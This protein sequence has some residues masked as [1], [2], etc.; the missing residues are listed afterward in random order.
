MT[1]EYGTAV[2]PTDAD[3]EQSG[4]SQVVA[5]AGD[6]ASNVVET[7]AGGIRD[8]G[9]EVKTQAQA[10]A[11]QAKQ[12][13]DDLLGQVRKEVLQQAQQRN[14]QAASQLH[15]WSD[16][17]VALAQ[18]TPEDA[19]PLVGYLDEV[20]HQVRRLA[21]R[22][23]QRGPQGVVEDVANFARRCPGVF[24]AGAVGLGFVIGRAVRAA[25]S[26]QRDDG[27]PDQWTAPSHSPQRGG[28]GSDA[29]LPSS[30]GPVGVA[31]GIGQ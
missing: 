2:P 24:L 25:S 19:G 15:T 23:D 18:G 12:Q 5:R 21:T 20:E 10:V 14:E 16:Q 6:E 9:D 26:A 22:L 13:L 4:P 28:F 30:Y 1:V 7:A 3:G 29:L 8:V 31:G 27:V 11:G 17:L